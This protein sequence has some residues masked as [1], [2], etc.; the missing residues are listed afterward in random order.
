MNPC[1]Y[2][3][4]RDNGQFIIPAQ[5]QTKAIRGNKNKVTHALDYENKN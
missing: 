1:G 4:S 3:I 2:F 5:A